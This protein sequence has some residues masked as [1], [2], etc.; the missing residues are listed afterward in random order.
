MDGVGNNLLDLLREALLQGLGDLGVASGV[1][2]LA[3]LLVGAGVVKS[4]GDL[5]LGGLGDLIDIVSGAVKV[6]GGTRV[7]IVPS[8]GPCRGQKSRRRG[9]RPGPSRWWG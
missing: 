6:R 4:V 5:L 1:G 3:G 2:D 9:R 8:P 7:E